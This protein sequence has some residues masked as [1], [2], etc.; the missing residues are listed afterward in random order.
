[1][2][3]F[4]AALPMYDWPENMAE[5]DAEWESMRKRLLEQGV[6]APLRLVRRNADMPPVPGGIRDAGGAVIAPDPAI[7][8]PDELDRDALWRHPKLLFSQ[9]CWGPLEHGL[10]KHVRVLGQPDYS[11]YEGGDGQYYSSAIVMRAG[12]APP[13]P[14]DSSPIPLDLL[15]G[16]RFA[17]NS[18][19]SLS[20]KI[21]FTRDLEAMGEDLSIFPEHVET[22]GHRNSII[23]VA[24]G[25]ADVAA[26]DC[27]S[28]ALARRFEPMAAKVV[29][30]GWTSRRKGLPFITAL[31]SPL[32][33]LP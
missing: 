23:A 31:E 1:M 11:A 9:A 33:K 26:I 10:G 16:R 27:R 30:V 24:E 13:A 3:K 8:P 21:A 25:R 17:Y 14:D 28:W 29:V 19:D 2:T 20:G 5:V 12:E 18:D 15:R 22:G 32:T 6:D 7:L 4:I